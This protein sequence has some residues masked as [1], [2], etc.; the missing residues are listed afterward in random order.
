[1]GSVLW[2]VSQSHA[3]ARIVMEMDIRRAVSTIPIAPVMIGSA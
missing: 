3:I 1:V 2:W